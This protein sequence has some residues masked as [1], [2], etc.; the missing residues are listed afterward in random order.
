[1][2]GPKLSTRNIL[3]EKGSW[4]TWGERLM[5]GTSGSSDPYLYP[6]TTVLKNLRGLKDPKALHA[7]EA[8]ST[9][10]RI[11]ELLDSPLPGRF[12]TFHLKSIHKFI[13]QD[14]Y[15]WAGRFRTVNLSKDGNL[16]AGS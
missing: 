2:T 4:P 12:D 7:Y 8:S 5:S 10:R 9:Y 15:T 1:M 6:G 11:S 14:V 13:F 16:F 3:T